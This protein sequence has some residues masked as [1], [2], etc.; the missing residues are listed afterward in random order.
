MTDE[1]LRELADEARCPVSFVERH[2]AGDRRLVE[3]SRRIERALRRRSGEAVDL[4]ALL[5]EHRRRSTSPPELREAVLTA[6]ADAPLTASR[7]SA[8]LGESKGRVA[9]ALCGLRRMGLVGHEARC[10]GCWRIEWA[11]EEVAA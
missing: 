8:L 4:P 1:E 11:T 5:A 9:N 3:T 6:L 10:G 2:L 7:L